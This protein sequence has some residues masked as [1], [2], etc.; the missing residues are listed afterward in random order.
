[1]TGVQTCA[2]PIYLAALD[3]VHVHHYGKT[4]KPQRKIGH[5]T[6]TAST[7]DALMQR[8]QPVLALVAQHAQ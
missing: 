7:R 1:V 4:P 5:L 8:L 6:V 2:L 3:G